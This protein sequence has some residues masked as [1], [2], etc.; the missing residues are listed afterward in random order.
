MF[1]RDYNSFNYVGD[2]RQ[3]TYSQVTTG[4]Q[5]RAGVPITEYVSFSARYQLSYDKVGLDQSTYF[6][7]GVC[8]PLLAGRY[9]CEAIGN[10]L[11]SAVG[12]SLIYDSLNS[13]LRPTAGSSLSISQD[14]AGLGGDVRYIK[15]Q[16]NGRHFWGLG[17]GFVLSANAE[18]GYIHPLERNRGPGIDA[19]R[20]TDRFYLGEPDFRGF[21]IRGVGP[22][23][24][25]IP[26]ITDASGNQVLQ[27][28][29]AQ[30]VDDALGGRAYYLGRLEMEI[31]LGAGARELGLRPSIYV[32]AGALFDI[33][34]PLPTATFATTVDPVTGRVTVL[35][36]NQQV[37][38]TNGAPLFVVPTTDAT[39]PGST[40][41][42]QVGFS[43]T[44]GGSCVGTSVNTAY[45]QQIAPFVERFLGNSARPRVSIGAGVN[46]N[47]PFGPLRVDAAYALVRVRGDD[48]KII[49]FNVGTQ[50]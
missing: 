33:T 20:I 40:T 2:N 19:V 44:V 14:I 8:N 50:F 23:V 17:S 29:R 38:A 46:W 31:P 42:C 24:Q 21:D 5:V 49:T 13:R 26:Y 28:D 47:S 11:T 3:T 22:R 15:T 7:N 4:A 18:G 41:T 27:T 34:R 39:N 37:F 48:T 32:Q 30:I 6:T 36:I 45:T 43:S 10:R 25:R 16:F 1:R 12:Y 35:P 9:L